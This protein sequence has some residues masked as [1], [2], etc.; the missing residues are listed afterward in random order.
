MGHQ[1]RPYAGTLSASRWYSGGYRAVGRG[2]DHGRKQIV[3]F[4]TR[5]SE[6]AK[7]RRCLRGFVRGWKMRSC[8]RCDGDRETA[9]FTFVVAS[10]VQES[11]SNML[12]PSLDIK[13]LCKM[14]GSTHL[15]QEAH[16][17]SILTYCVAC[18]FCL[19]SASDVPQPQACRRPSAFQIS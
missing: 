16:V 17:P 13:T 18:P 12:L 6:Q 14:G 9:R 7:K 5:V 10:A 3:W 11:T 15:T 4:L 2:G 19:I 8:W 1:C